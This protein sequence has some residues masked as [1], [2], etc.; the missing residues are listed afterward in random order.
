[1]RSCRS[2]PHSRHHVRLIWSL[3]I[4]DVRTFGPP[5]R[6]VP[7]GIVEVIF[8]HGT[9]FDMRYDG[10]PFMRQPTI[11]VV[12]QTRR[13]SEIRPA[14]PSGFISVRFQPWGTCQFV[15]VPLIEL[16]D[17]LTDPEAIWGR[18]AAVLKMQL[19]AATSMSQRSRLVQSFLLAQ[20]RVNRKPDVE[21]VVRALW[22]Q[23]PAVR[24]G[25]LSQEIG[26]TERR[27]ERT[28]ATA[29][30]LSPKQF[31]R[32][33]RFLR[34]CRSIRERR[35]ATLADVAHEAGYYDQAH[36]IAEF[37]TFA[38]M[39]PRALLGQK[40]AFLEID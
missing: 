9:P 29:I 15:D 6:I 28:F 32:L 38:G 5:E 26:M 13:F 21:G 11:A 24:I 12:S 31:S 37:K 8:H 34:A 20:L 17:R 7:D 39:T 4:D 1:M 27:L 16:A 10:E 18:A 30:G 3:E 19:D 35:A 22:S 14:G 23:K 36:C 25:M 33:A 40:V 2:T